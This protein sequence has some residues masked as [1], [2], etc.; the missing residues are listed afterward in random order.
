MVKSVLFGY[1]FFLK[2]HLIKCSER[3]PAAQRSTLDVPV[4]GH[5]C[6]LCSQEH[7]IRVID[8]AHE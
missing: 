6:Y 4:S 1:V 8:I 5:K 2:N 7:F 3:F